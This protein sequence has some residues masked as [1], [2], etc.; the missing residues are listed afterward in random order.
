MNG[1]S[2]S[3]NGNEMGNIRPKHLSQMK[4]F[5]T[6][7]LWHRREATSVFYRKECIVSKK[8]NTF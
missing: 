3:G 6:Y 7:V 8:D 4:F 1:L 5:N 2:N